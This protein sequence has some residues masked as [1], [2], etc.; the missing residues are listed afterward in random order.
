[1][2]KI[3]NGKLY[4][5]DTARF[6]A[7]CDY[8]TGSDFRYFEESLYITK[9]WQ[10][11]IQWEGWPMTKYCVRFGSSMNWS[12]DIFLVNKKEIFDWLEENNNYFY[13]EDIE[14]V[15]LE[16]WDEVEEG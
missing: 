3:I 1:M 13:K 8:L 6:V 14:K 16:L 5:T 11:F 10:Y 12:S 7:K 15:L 9:K 4:N 2:K